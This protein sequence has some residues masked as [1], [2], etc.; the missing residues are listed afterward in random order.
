[1][2]GSYL[3]TIIL[4]GITGGYVA[5]EIKR[6]LSYYG[7]ATVCG[8]SINL[9]NTNPNFLVMEYST[10]VNVKGGNGI[11]VL[12]GQ[13]TKNSVLDVP[14]NYKGIVYSSDKGALELLRDNNITAIT[15]GMSSHDTLIL[16][17]IGERTASVCVQR[18]IITLSGKT[19]EAGEY[20]IRLKNKITDYALLAAFG[21]LLM[22]DIEPL[23]IEY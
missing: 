23:D 4:F 2:R 15:C 17:S 20:P 8:T 19:I 5:D 6:I 16:S 13:I 3:K 22:C 9:A 1:M 11:V 7:I 21:I 14:Y 18:K 12:I 10:R